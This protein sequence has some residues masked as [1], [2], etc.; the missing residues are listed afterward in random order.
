[1]SNES[2]T[3]LI[4][5][6]S[7]E[8]RIATRRY[9][10]AGMAQSW[11]VIEAGDGERGIQLWRELQPDCV[12]LDYSMPDM[13]GLEVLAVLAQ[14]AHN[15]APVIMLTTAG[16]T[17]IAVQALK[18]GAQDYLIK[19]QINPAT[20]HRAI[21]NTLERVRLYDERKQAEV[22]RERLHREAEHAR[23]I[24]EEAV[25]LRDEFLAIEAH[26]LKN[27]LAVLN[28]Y[29][30]LL[31]HRTASPN[32]LDDRDRQA[33]RVISGQVTRLNQMIAGLLDVSSIEL[34]TFTVNRTALDLGGLVRRLVEEDVRPSLKQHTLR[35]QC[36]SLPLLIRGD[37]LRLEQ[38]LHN[39]I[40]NAIRY[41]PKGGEITVEVSKHDAKVAVTIADQGIGIPAT[42]LLNL[43]Q[44]FYRAANAD[45]EQLHGTG[46][47]LYVVKQI[48]TLHGGEVSVESKEGE[49]SKFSIWLPMVSGTE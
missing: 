46:I 39:L 6:D 25:R 5:D 45:S 13:S 42:A 4:I 47:G 2:R 18:L 24:A 19:D 44:R 9:L 41:S 48:I 49:G 36:P 1:M 21:T 20:L 32:S 35:F 43:F 3:I 38:V 17:T 11:T 12:I 22:E 16:D 31:E 14:E 29:A 40:N 28:V 27:V 26:E 34:G 30:Q 33:L 8:D 23:A 37:A 15:V 10:M 7:P